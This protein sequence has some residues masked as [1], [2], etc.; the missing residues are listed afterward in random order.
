MELNMNMQCLNIIYHVHPT[1]LEVINRMGWRQYLI[2]AMA[3]IYC[4]LFHNYPLYPEPHKN[5][6]IEI[7]LCEYN[8]LYLSKVG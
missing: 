4:T 6:Y 1:P 8:D 3:L 7:N 5:V 2:L